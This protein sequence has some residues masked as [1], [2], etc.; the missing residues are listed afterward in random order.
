MKIK[1]NFRDYWL[2]QTK[3]IK[4]KKKPK[5]SLINNLWFKDG[6]LNVAQNCLDENLK[7]GFSKKKAIIF[8]SKEGLIENI[9]YENLY[10]SVIKF[11]LKLKDFSRSNKINLKRI[12]IHTSAS[13]ES[14]V[15]M[16]AC[17]SLGISHAV[18]F[19]EL[20]ADAISSRIELFKPDIIITRDSDVM[21]KNKIF[22][23][24][25][26]LGRK[27][28]LIIFRK[29]K[30]NI[31][32]NLFISSLN[33]YQ[34]F[35]VKI[36]QKIKHYKSTKDFFTLFTSGS[37]GVP[38]GIV[39]SYGNYLLYAKYTCKKYFGLNSKS[40]V[41][42]ASDAAWINGH[43]YALYG[44]LTIGATTVLLENP[45]IICDHRVLNNLLKKIK[46]TVLYLPVTI[47]R[48]LK[49]LNLKIPKNKDLKTLGSM[50][51]PLAPEVG[52]WFA[53]KFDKKKN[54][55]VN[56]Y[57]QTETGGVISAP[58]Y[59]DRNNMIPHGS[60]GIPEK[61]LNLSLNKQNEIII[62]N[63]WPGCMKKILNHNSIWK[64]YWNQDGSFNMF[65]IGSINKKNILSIHG[66]SDDVINI[67]GHRIGSE[68]IESIL[69]TIKEI[70]EV[71]AVSIE[72]DLEG[73]RIVIFA[74]VKNNKFLK[75]KIN[76]KLISFF[77]TFALP[78]NIFFV[79]NLP[80]TRSGKIMRRILKELLENK[81]VNKFGDLSTVLDKKSI[82]SIE[83]SIRNN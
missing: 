80:K 18:I 68:E 29:D 72:D 56:T 39:H 34:N 49:S 75:E 59:N 44:P 4:W 36:D 41:L 46:I 35:D 16:L 51:E 71:S 47:I 20:Q 5:K 25:K 64:K 76:K 69:L 10:K 70:I 50:G 62:K 73:N 52:S 12:L 60:V 30:T 65:D 28:P 33:F 6:T 7:K 53:K 40:V 67:R 66:R 22:K 43:T 63:S 31:K 27:K 45:M 3:I 13:F 83:K 54:C 81:D 55:I 58:K 9:T 24:F 1:K 57:F 74:K 37:T 42:C 61:F 8:I 17:S 19:E 32:K 21:I 23:A 2:N 11:S 82:F 26:L 79:E 15:S 77:G 14:A 78:K 38:K 48:L